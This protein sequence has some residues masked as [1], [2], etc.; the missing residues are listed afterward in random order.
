MYPGIASRKE[1]NPRASTAIHFRENEEL[2]QEASPLIPAVNIAEFPGEYCIRI[3]VPGLQNED[4]NIE[5]KE[6]VI[7]ISA[8][9]NT[10]T[11]SCINNRCEFDY[12]DWTRAFILPE[13]ADAILTNARYKNGELYI[14]IPRDKSAESKAKAT[15]YVY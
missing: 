12:H 13:D 10:E 6:G 8:Q 2:N 7:V 1:F 4:F 9:K 14:R 5:L 11:A 3:A 15:V